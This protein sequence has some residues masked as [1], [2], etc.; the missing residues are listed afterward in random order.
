M[1]KFKA[2]NPK[3]IQN[4]SVENVHFAFCHSRASGNPNLI[5]GYLLSQV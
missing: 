2:L 3:Q 4:C 1:N 5:Y